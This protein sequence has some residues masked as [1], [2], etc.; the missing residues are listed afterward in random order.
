MPNSVMPAGAAKRDA[1]QPAST[2]R[3]SRGMRYR[4]VRPNG[5]STPAVRLKATSSAMDRARVVPLMAKM[6]VGRSSL[7]R[8]RKRPIATKAPN[9]KI[10]NKAGRAAD[11]GEDR[12]PLQTR[13]NNTAAGDREG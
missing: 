13:F 12:Q 10:A 4:P 3:R 8:N 2:V 9:V 7:P 11:S 5:Y 1:A 6:V